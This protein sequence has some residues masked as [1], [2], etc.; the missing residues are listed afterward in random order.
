MIKKFHKCKFKKRHVKNSKIKMYYKVINYL[1]SEYKAN[2][3]YNQLR[4]FF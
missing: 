1:K 3:I 2:K 4:E